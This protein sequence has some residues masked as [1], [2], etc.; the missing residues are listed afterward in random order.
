[1]TFL[2]T[3]GTGFLGTYVAKQLLEQG[4][5][6]VI[7]S[8]S[9]PRANSMSEVLTK[10]QI[11]QLTYAEGDVTDLARLIH[12]CQEN[13]VEMIIHPAGLLLADCNKNPLRAVQTNIIGTLNVF[14]AARICGMKR[15]VWASSNSAI[16]TAK[17]LPYEFLPN[18]APHNPVTIY[19]KIKDF[20]EFMGDFYYK[21]YGLETIG[22]RYVV[23]YGKGRRRGGANYIK[24]MLNDPALGIPSVVDAADDNPNFVYVEDAARATVLATKC[25][26][27]R[28]AYNITGEYINMMELRDYVLT[29]LPDAKIDMIPGE[30]DIAWKFDTTVEEEELG[31]KP[32]VGIREGALMTINDVR[33]G[34]GL[35]PVG[36]K[37]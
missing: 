29:L 3:G 6:V 32:S 33:A 14:E 36:E 7:M 26:Y 22:L 20:N 28:N 12:I 25:E 15:V 13:K 2:I 17:N 19:G 34:A 10:E 23:I 5:K 24:Y 31:Y 16:G 37:K 8:R 9:A 4:D 11:D 1:M 21:K 35:P 30:M 18:D 27:K